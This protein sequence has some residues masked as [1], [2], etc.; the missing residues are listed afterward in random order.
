MYNLQQFRALERL[1]VIHKMNLKSYQNV[2]FDLEF[3]NTDLKLDLNCGCHLH[4]SLKHPQ[5]PKTLSCNY[6]RSLKI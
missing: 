4:F 1:D 6:C 2:R 3:L 5:K